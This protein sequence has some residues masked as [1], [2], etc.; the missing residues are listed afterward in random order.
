MPPTAPEGMGCLGASQ[1]A[2]FLLSSPRAYSRLPRNPPS[3]S[4]GV[5]S[6]ISFS[7]AAGTLMRSAT[8]REV[9][10]EASSVPPLKPLVRPWRALER[11]VR[12]RGDRPRWGRSLGA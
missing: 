5:L 1:G 6:G 10:G 8:R 11:G 12:G 3:I 7:L 2:A 9:T 4:V